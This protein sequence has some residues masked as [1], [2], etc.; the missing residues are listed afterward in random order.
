MCA[1]ERG[2]TDSDG[3]SMPA[4]PTTR[5]LGHLRGIGYGGSRGA[6]RHR[7]HGVGRRRRRAKL[8]VAD[9]PER[10]QQAREPP[11]HPGA[12]RKHATQG[13]TRQATATA[14]PNPSQCDHYGAS[15]VAAM[16][17]PAEAA[18]AAYK[19]SGGDAVVHESARRPPTARACAAHLRA[20]LMHRCYARVRHA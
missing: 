13:T 7:I 12:P 5:L 16:A 15:V 6:R 8:S 20:L 18:T 2:H 4:P 11:Q 10:L 14:Q 1:T 19:V 9:H 3:T 17:A